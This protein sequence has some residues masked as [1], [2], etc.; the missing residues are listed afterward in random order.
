MDKKPKLYN[1]TGPNGQP[2]EKGAWKKIVTHDENN[3]KG[4]FGE[5][6]FLSNAISSVVFLDG[7]QYPS[8]ENA[9]KAWRWKKEDRKYFE[10]HSPIEAI[11]YNRENTP[12]G[13]SEEEWEAKKAEVMEFLLRQKFDK[14]LNPSL[15][16]K[17]K[18]TGSKYLEETNWWGD[19]FWGVDEY[20]NGENNLGKT[21][22]R[23]REEFND[24]ESI[25]I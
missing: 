18:S 13:P 15:H 25:M 23:V 22:M 7:V 10:T 4:F 3:I 9:Y 2:Y 5:Y 19:I 6:R 1:E 16:D 17:L 24:E 8:V 14:N 11:A 20:G 21:L 12:N